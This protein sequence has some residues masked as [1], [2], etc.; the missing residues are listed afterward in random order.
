[1]KFILICCFFLTASLLHSQVYSDKV[2]D[3][4]VKSI[5]MYGSQSNLSQIVFPLLGNSLCTVE[6]DILESEI[7]DLRYEIFLCNKYWQKSE[8]LPSEYIQSIGIL[9]I[10]NIKNS[11]NTTVPYI[12]YQFSFPH[13]DL[14][15][16]YSG[17]YI[18][19]VIN[20][21]TNQILFQKRFVVAEM[22]VGLDVDIKQAT[23]VAYMDTHQEV[24]FRIKPLGF[25]ISNPTNDLYTAIVQ[26]GR[27]NMAILGLQPSH[28]SPEAIIYDYQKENLFLGG[29][30]FHQINFKNFKF[31]AQHIKDFTYENGRFSVNLLPNEMRT[32]K[33]YE[34][35]GDLNGRF[36][37]SHDVHADASVVGDYA[38]VNFC[39]SHYKTLNDTL[40]I[41]VI[42]A[43]N[44][45][46]I[47]EENKMIYNN[48]KSEY[49]ASILLKQGYIDYC[50]A[51]VSNDKK[52]VNSHE[53][54]GTYYQTE[55]DYEVFVYFY[56]VLNNYD[57]V[58][59]YKKLNS[60]K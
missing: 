36:L 52:I 14:Q 1:M 39:L 54:E 5:Q 12:H 60:K 53:I 21:Q 49:E 11:I 43:F 27:W 4:K 15:F 33:V 44:Q 56:D 13:Q 46:Q 45:W 59:A 58:I 57:R 50:F 9:T 7:K 47:N 32:Y 6:F 30:E 18:L 8:L 17:N 23:D 37:P 34:N 25:S 42:G 10:D 3:N 2:F 28:I 48:Q 41:Y 29:A 22:I 19:Q 55:N 51:Y 26:N 31:I 24:D 35:N 38:Y 40:D 16:I 20:D